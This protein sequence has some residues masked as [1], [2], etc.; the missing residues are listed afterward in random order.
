M[1]SRAAFILTSALLLLG[2]GCDLGAKVSLRWPFELSK[3]EAPDVSEAAMAL[4][5]SI[6]ATL[7]IQPS[8]LG[9]TGTLA[10]L[11][12]SVEGVKTATVKAFGPGARAEIEWTEK[13]AP[14]R[15]GTVAT[16]SSEAAHEMFLPVFWKPG[17]RAKTAASLIWLSPEAWRELDGKGSTEWKL[18]LGGEASVDAALKTLQ[19]FN[20]LASRL[21][22]GSAASATATSPFRMRATGSPAFP[23]RVDGELVNVKTIKASS[24]F[25]DYVVLA[26]PEN[27]LILKVSVNPVAV[28][29]LDALKPLEADVSALGY[30]ITSISSP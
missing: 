8:F 13:S 15:S 21:S 10:D 22:G 6:G 11:V 18:G 2:A 29:A 4:K 24:W 1:S 3:P 30:E 23:L 14:E 16:E 27:P 17:E 9:V 12:G 19:A 7:V 20:D 5:T 28:G 25:A 26:N